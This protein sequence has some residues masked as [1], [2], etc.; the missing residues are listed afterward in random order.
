LHSYGP[1]THERDAF[2]KTPIKIDIPIFY[3]LRGKNECLFSSWFQYELQQESLMFHL[4]RSILTIIFLLV[5]AAAT[6]SAQTD[7][8]TLTWTPN[9]ESN[10]AGYN[11]Y[12]KRDTSG[13]PYD[14]TGL[15]QDNSPITIY[16][17]DRTNENNRLLDNNNPEFVL[18]GMVDGVTYYMALTAFNNEGLES[19]YSNEV[20]YTRQAPVDLDHV[21]IEG[22]Q[23]VP[24]NSAAQFILRAYFSNNTNG[25]VNASSWELNCGDA[26]I[27]DDGL[28]TTE[29][30]TVNT[31][32]TVLATYTAGGITRSDQMDFTIEDSDTVTLD[33]IEI[34]GPS[35]VGENSSETYS[36]IAYYTDDTSEMVFAESWSTDCPNADISTNGVLTTGEVSGNSQC[37]ISSIYLS[38][39]NQTNI[40]IEDD[41]TTAILIQIAI[42]GPSN[43][44][45]GSNS[46]YACRAFYSDG[47]DK[48]ITPDSWR[49]KYGAS[50]S[51]ITN[52][53]I[54]ITDEVYKDERVD[55]E[56]SYSE[57]QSSES[58]EVQVTVKDADTPP[59]E[60]IMDNGDPGTSYTGYWK[61]SYNASFG[62]PSVYCPKRK[63]GDYSFSNQ[64]NGD[65]QVLFRWIEKKGKSKNVKVEIFDGDTL[66][67]IVTVDQ[68]QNADNWN[69]LGIY[70][71][72]GLFRV[73][74]TASKGEPDISVDGMKFLRK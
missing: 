68:T 56:A 49:I 24:E 18:T 33:H 29:E 5:I 50:Y 43:V 67:D 74:V 38:Q 59:S 39:S 16:L 20:S 65:Y 8:I 1:A 23:T 9:T 22:P 11:L 47:S 21:E 31:Q 26:S 37:T 6:G 40:I 4:I 25:Q 35:V 14:G 10:L 73:N 36:C 41:N 54:L 70:R 2:F 30:V 63:A 71:F 62:N 27:S 64:L 61:T 51:Y 53:G 32:S 15:D 44:D 28:L 34:T 55:I 58:D 69:L 48:F 52:D 57:G 42:E 46:S 17:S 13:P 19:G 12:Y 3:I 7:S 45:E 72:N 60:I 66:L